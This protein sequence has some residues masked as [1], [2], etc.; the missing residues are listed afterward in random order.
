[1]PNVNELESLV[2]VSRASPAIASGAPFTNVTQANAYWSSTTYQGTPT[3]AW[4]VDFF[5]GSV[6][7]GIK[8]SN[9]YVRA[10]RGGS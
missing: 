9:Y 4:A 10:V 5:V 3:Y 1:M 2:D 6:Y 8:S 7:D